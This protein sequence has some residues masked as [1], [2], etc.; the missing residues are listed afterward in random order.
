[1]TEH[2]I[3]WQRLR[4]RLGFRLWYLHMSTYPSS[5]IPQEC[6][7][8]APIITDGTPVL[9]GQLIGKVGHA[10]LPNGPHLH[11]EVRDASGRRAWNRSV[12]VLESVKAEKG[13]IYDTP[14]HR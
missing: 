14:N 8:E 10:G 12:Y 7:L 2:E 4:C 5:G 11:S 1:M 13:G 6:I 9:A 3:R